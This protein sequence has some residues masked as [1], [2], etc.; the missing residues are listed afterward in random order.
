MFPLFPP[1]ITITQTLT[2]SHNTSI[3]D[4]NY[5]DRKRRVPQNRH[6]YVE[7]NSL[8]PINIQYTTN[9]LATYVN[10]SIGPIIVG[11]LR[12]KSNTTFEA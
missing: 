12:Y 1:K 2:M 7:G 3:R 6:T 8:I 4:L 9:P 10:F 5:C 11:K